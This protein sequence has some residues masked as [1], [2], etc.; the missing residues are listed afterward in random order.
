[1]DDTFTALPRDLVQQ[2]L[3]HLNSIE[4]CIQFT[5]EEETEGKL[6][7][8]DVCLQREGN[9]SLTTSVFRKATHTNQYLSFDSHHPVARKAVVVRT[10]IHRASTLSS[11]SVERVAKEKKV[12]LENA[13]VCMPTHEQ[14]Q[15]VSAHGGVR[16]LRHQLFCPKDH[17]PRDQRAGVVYQIPQT[18]HWSVWKDPETP[19]V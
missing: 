14:L 13:Y 19:V 5:A 9:G 10:L 4:P 16:T 2:F 8:L 18:V 11:N 7:F 12:I 3:S 17:V 6:P 15:D 1:M